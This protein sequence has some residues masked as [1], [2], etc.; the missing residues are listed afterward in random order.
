[1]LGEKI[2]G[3]LNV[4]IFNLTQKIF[5]ILSKTN[6]TSLSDTIVS[7]SAGHRKFFFFKSRSPQNP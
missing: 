5:Q 4:L 6:C 7:G 2:G 3:R 1:M